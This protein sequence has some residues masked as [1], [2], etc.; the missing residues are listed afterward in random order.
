M[1]TNVRVNPVRPAN[2][3]ATL[4][5]A[6]ASETVVD[7]GALAAGRKPTDVRRLLNVAGQ[8]GPRGRAFLDG[9]AEQ[10]AEDLAGL[11]LEYGVSTFILA[12]DDPATIERFGAEVAPATR[13]LVAAER[14]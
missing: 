1:T 9:P 4:N 7:E 2:L 5:P 12:V 10:W 3:N 14:G 13:E 6:G 8:F 11:T